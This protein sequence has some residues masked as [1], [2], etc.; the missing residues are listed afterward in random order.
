LRLGQN[1]RIT[2]EKRFNLARH[3]EALLQLYHGLQY[4]A[5]R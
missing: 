3:A 2:A 4:A 1:A 5:L